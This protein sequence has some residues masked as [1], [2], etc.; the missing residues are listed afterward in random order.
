MKDLRD[1]LIDLAFRNPL[2][3]FT[4]LCS[5]PNSCWAFYLFDHPQ[6]RLR[7]IKSIIENHCGKE[8]K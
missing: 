8:L 5:E 3:K 4:N 6:Y 1:N 2:S 7:N